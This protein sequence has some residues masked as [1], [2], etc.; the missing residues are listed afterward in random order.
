MET[1]DGKR[2]K[3]NIAR[4]T[5]RGT[6]YD[7]KAEAD[8]HLVLR[9]KEKS[10]E[11]EALHYHGLRFR[12]G[13]SDKGRPV[14]FTPDFTYI[15]DGVLVAEEIKGPVARDF[16][17]RSAMFKDKYPEWELRVVPA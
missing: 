12:L 1:V 3:Y 17:V 16:P 6:R 11:I 5:V 14:T 13:T 2:T 8:R 9:D 15:D 4:L 10:G 7:S